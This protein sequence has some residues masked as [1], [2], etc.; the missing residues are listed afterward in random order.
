MT[1]P[2]CNDK[3]T[4][5]YGKKYGLTTKQR[6]LCKGCKYLL[7]VLL[8]GKTIEVKTIRRLSIRKEMLRQIIRADLAEDKNRVIKEY[9]FIGKAT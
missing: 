1:F 9:D 8:P 2:R 6:D 4:I 7:N 5:K 3:N